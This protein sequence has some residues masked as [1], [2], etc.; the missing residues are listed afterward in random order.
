MALEGSLIEFG[1]PDILQ[2]IYFQKKTG[3]LTL[4]SRK[5]R[6]QLVFHE[7][8]IMAAD[9]LRRADENRLGRILVR[10]GL[11]TED[12]FRAALESQ[13]SSG[14]KLGN[15]LIIKGLVARE[16]VTAAIAAQVKD[17]VIQLF[18][19]KEGAYEFQAHPVTPGREAPLTLDTQHL[20][21]EGLRVLDEWSLIE[22]KVTL[23]TVFMRKAT[24]PM[25][26]TPS[27]ESVFAHVDGENDVRS[28][29]DLSGMDDF[30]ASKAIL[31]LM[32]KGL[33]EAVEISPVAVAPVTLPEAAGKRSSP[34]FLPLAFLLV[35]LIVSLAASSQGLKSKGAPGE[36]DVF[37]SVKR[38]EAVREI[39]ALRFRAEEFRYRHGSYPAD[40]RQ[41]GGGRDAWGSP[42]LYRAEQDGVVIISAGPDGR[43][44]TADDVY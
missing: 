19:W 1:L 26:L 13:K 41:L 36:L 28:L 18:S 15:I 8:N 3:V 32:Q 9:S 11:I 2:L 42:Y 23:D 35:A 4:S 10:K 5:D 12:D 16:D 22:G 24:P 44:E 40:I 39:E 17:T 7:G 6:A 31:S 43:M 30:E 37:A 29:T 38:S 27:E 33:V 20:L 25:P 34:S 14:G 21:M